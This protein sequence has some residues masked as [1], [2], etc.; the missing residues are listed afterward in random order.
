M[1]GGA[2]V[3]QMEDKRNLYRIFADKPEMKWPLGRCRNSWEANFKLDVT[4]GALL[5]TR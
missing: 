2:H 4:S 1:G 3:A 5:C